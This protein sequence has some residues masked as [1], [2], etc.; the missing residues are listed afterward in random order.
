[1]PTRTGHAQA[2]ARLDSTG[3]KATTGTGAMDIQSIHPTATDGPLGPEARE[4]LKV[5][6]HYLGP[7]TLG[8]LVA[9]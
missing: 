5:R 9:H 1:M 6:R 4:K 8:H 2:T 3:R 7:N